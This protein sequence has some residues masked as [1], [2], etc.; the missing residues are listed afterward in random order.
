MRKKIKPFNFCEAGVMLAFFVV[1]CLS[2]DNAQN[3]IK[4]R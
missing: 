4:P 1:C 3:G 2:S